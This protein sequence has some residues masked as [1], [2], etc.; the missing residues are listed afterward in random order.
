[1]KNSIQINHWSLVIGHS[2]RSQAGFTLIEL[3]MVM[4]ILSVLVG[5]FV[6][7][8][9]AS[10]GRARDTQRKNDL[11]QYQTTLELAANRNNG[12]YPSRT[13]NTVM[14][15]DTF[16]VTDIGFSS[17]ECP[18]D[19]KD[20]STSCNSNTCR[21]YYR[22]N[23]GGTGTFDATDYVLWSALERPAGDDYWVV[24]SSGKSGE[25]SAEPSSSTCPL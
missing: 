6:T 22:S 19:P 1:M 13:S 25:N 21:Y 20:N 14:H 8:Y 4:G 24:C 11:K 16:C 3:I 10:Q 12:L 17:G 15:L 5:F 23:G 9:P 18:K 7:Q 2:W